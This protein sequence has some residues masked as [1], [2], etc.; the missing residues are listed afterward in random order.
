MLQHTLSPSSPEKAL[1]ESSRGNHSKQPEEAAASTAEAQKRRVSFAPIL[2]GA[3][4]DPDCVVTKVDMPAFDQGKEQRFGV[5]E[6]EHTVAQNKDVLADQMGEM[7][8]YQEDSQASTPSEAAP[9]TPDTSQSLTILNKDDFS[10]GSEASEEGSIASS[11]SSSTSLYEQ[12]QSA[13]RGRG[14][15]GRPRGKRGRGKGGE[16]AEDAEVGEVGEDNT[17]RG[18]GARG[19]KRRGRGSR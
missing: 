4:M 7:T 10:P 2:H 15:R 3:G 8:T 6:Q 13:K 1:K 11:L 16:T 5:R 14:K 18:R 19:R 12:P 9:T 17:V